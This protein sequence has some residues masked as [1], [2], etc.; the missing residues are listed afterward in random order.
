M[1]QPPP[2]LSFSPHVLR[3]A[4]AL[5]AALVLAELVWRVVATRWEALNRIGAELVRLMHPDMPQTPE[6]AEIAS[7]YGHVLW[8]LLA[9]VIAWTVLRLVK[10]TIKADLWVPSAWVVLLPAAVVGVTVSAFVLLVQRGAITPEERTLQAE[11]EQATGSGPA[12][13]DRVLAL[14]S[15]CHDSIRKRLKGKGVV[16]IDDGLAP[17]GSYVYTYTKRDVRFVRIAKSERDVSVASIGAPVQSLMPPIEGPY[18]V[19]GLVNYSGDNPQVSFRDYREYRCSMQVTD[20]RYE[21][22]DLRINPIR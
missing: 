2:K 6:A 20:G 10:A 13:Y 18:M 17:V 11:I 15:N 8:L 12:S 4:L 3:G 9:L 19:E 21:V 7:N 14:L 1:T 16:I 5:A 22:R